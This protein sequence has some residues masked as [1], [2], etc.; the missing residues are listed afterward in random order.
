VFKVALGDEPRQ[1]FAEMPMQQDWR[2]H[3]LRLPRSLRWK[4]PRT[5][6]N[7]SKMPENRQEMGQNI[8]IH[9]LFSQNQNL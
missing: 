7:A 2:R 3:S 1:H 6:Q 4:G 8:P 5:A 9:L